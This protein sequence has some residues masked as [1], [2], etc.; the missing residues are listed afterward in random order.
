MVWSK[1]AG[2]VEK[3][4][5]GQ[6]VIKSVGMRNVSASQGERRLKSTAHPKGSQENMNYL[7]IINSGCLAFGHAVLQSKVDVSWED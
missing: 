5:Q 1:N 6:S 3:H 2:P 7:S 4:T